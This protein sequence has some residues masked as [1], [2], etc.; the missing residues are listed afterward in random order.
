MNYIY[1]PEQE[2]LREKVRRFAEQCITPEALEYDHRGN[3]PLATIQKMGREG[4][5][6]PILPKE[7]G[8]LGLRTLEY[9]LITQ[10]IAAAS[11]AY[12]HNGQFQT[13]KGILSFGTPE[14]K[15][16]YLPKLATAEAIGA[17]AISEHN[18]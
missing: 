10:E 14:Q 6:A 2:R 13:Q 1:S 16:M 12:T 15:S 8:G 18:V 3:Y 4:F 7:Y 5:F 11:P 9:G 17:I